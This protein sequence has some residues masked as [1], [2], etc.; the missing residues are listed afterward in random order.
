MRESVVPARD[1]G[2]SRPASYSMNTRSSKVTRVVAAL[3]DVASEAMAKGR[4]AWPSFDVLSPP[5]PRR[6][7]SPPFA[8]G[9]ASGV[10]GLGEF[11]SLRRASPAIIA[12]GARS[13]PWHS[14]TRT[15]RQQAQ[16]QRGPRRRPKHRPA[17]A[18]PSA[19]SAVCGPVWEDSTE[20]AR[21]TGIVLVAG[22][23]KRVAAAWRGTM[24]HRVEAPPATG[25]FS[26]GRSVERRI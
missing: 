6:R 20:L 18:W 12:C 22:G 11:G 15:Q 21:A 8:P 10:Q 4:R 17:P 13:L 19:P 14:R 3:E 7:P 25:P 26:E 23:R 16:W 2:F 5:P 24:R 9:K 1:A